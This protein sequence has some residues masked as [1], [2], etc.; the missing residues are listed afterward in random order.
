MKLIGISRCTD[1]IHKYTA[2]L[3]NNKVIHKVHFGAKG[4]QDYTTTNSDDKKRA[5]IARHGV[6][7]NWTKS[8]ILTPGFWARWIL[9]N[10]KTI[11]QSI[12]D[13][14]ERFLL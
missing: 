10:K 3:E 6:R 11:A 2:T 9:W 4:Y 12:A 7:E 13:V 5:Y 14:K 1:T 8:G